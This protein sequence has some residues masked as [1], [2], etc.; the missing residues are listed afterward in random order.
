M[1][2]RPARAVKRLGTRRRVLQALSMLPLCLAVCAV[3]AALANLVRHFVDST[4][5]GKPELVCVYRLGAREFER[6]YPV[7]NFC[8]AYEEA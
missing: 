3:H 8:P 7:G 2:R 4:V 1:F 5:S 6:R